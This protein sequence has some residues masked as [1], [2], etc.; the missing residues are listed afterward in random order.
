M[1]LV[2]VICNLK[3]NFQKEVTVLFLEEDGSIQL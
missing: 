3:R 1:K 2:I